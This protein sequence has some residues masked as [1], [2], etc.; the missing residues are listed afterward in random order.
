M[1]T[2]ELFSPDFWEQAWKLAAEADKRRGDAKDAAQAWSRRARS[3]DKNVASESGQ[4]R[5][6]DAL[7]FLD[8]NNVPASG[9][10]IL[11]LGCGP[12]NFAV[13]FARRG[14]TVTALDPAEK[15]LELVEEKVKNMPE[16]AGR[17]T[18]VQG[19]WN[20][21]DPA[22]LGWEKH[23][24]LVFASMT[25]GVHDVATLK[26]AM[27]VSRKYM[28]LSRFAGPRKVP[29]LQTVW[30][31]L[32]GGDYHSQSLDVLFPLNWLYSSGYRPVLQYHHWER[33]HRQT[34]EEALEEIMDSLAMR[35]KVDGETEKRVRQII[36]R[37]ATD[38]YITERK[39]A[40]AGML[41]WRVDRGF[42]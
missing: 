22:R 31:E 42:L 37:E 9:L 20:E 40:T 3:Y 17:V 13:A 38:S 4:K 1:N 8:R 24:D 26:K 36:E 35:M 2:R 32:T 29:L 6:E 41:L 15:M 33:E 28:Y 25:P 5:V 34:T 19:D 18:T 16:I 10:R 30:R 39:G 21:I 23:F 27:G 12:G 7:S 14:N 11:D